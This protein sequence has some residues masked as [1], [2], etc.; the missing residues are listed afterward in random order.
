MFYFLELVYDK[1]NQRDG[2]YGR[3]FLDLNADVGNILLNK[4]YQIVY[5]SKSKHST[6]KRKFGIM[7]EEKPSIEILLEI[8]SADCLESLYLSG[9]PGVNRKEEVTEATVEFIANAYSIDKL[10]NFKHELE[11][12]CG[13]H[14]LE[15]SSF[16]VRRAGTDSMLPS[17]LDGY[18]NGPIPKVLE[19]YYPILKSGLHYSNCK[20]SFV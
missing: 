5:R 2:V 12:L 7:M 6:G 8:K 1:R 20:I 13:T 16:N 18:I 17:H 4:D 19:L 11:Q 9:S 15:S 10:S 14:Q 3:E